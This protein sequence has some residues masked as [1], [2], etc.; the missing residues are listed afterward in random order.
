MSH[1][2]YENRRHALLLF[3]SPNYSFRDF[4]FNNPDQIAL[5]FQDRVNGFYLVPAERLSATRDAFAAG[6]EFLSK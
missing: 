5:A 3:V 4:D 2:S 1:A 6:L